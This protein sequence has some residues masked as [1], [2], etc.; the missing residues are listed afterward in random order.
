MEQQ[1]LM[2]AHL[3]IIRFSEYSQPTVETYHSE[4]E[5]PFKIL[6]LVDNE[7]GDPRSLMELYKIN[8][9]M[10]VNTAS[11]LQPVD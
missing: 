2:S 6:F 10:P 7:P 11:I 9:F 3:F 5:I 1:S 4:K 8:I